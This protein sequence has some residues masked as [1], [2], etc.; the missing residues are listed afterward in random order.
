MNYPLVIVGAGGFGRELLTWIGEQSAGRSSH[1]RGFLDDNPAA[2]E[3]FDIELPILG[4][5]LTYQ[6]S[7]DERLVL[8]IGQPAT[9]LKLAELLRSRGGKFAT[10]IHTS[11]R[12]G[13]R[14]Q[15]GEGVIISPNAG[16]SCDV[17]LGDFVMLNCFATVGHDAHIGRGT[18][19]SSHV[20]CTGNTRIGAGV[21]LGSHA[22]VIPGIAVGDGATVAAGSVAMRNVPA[23]A[24]VLGVPAKKIF[25][26]PVPSGSGDS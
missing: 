12:V 4:D 3:D 11:A 6:P 25:Q 2:L 19:L 14:C 9:K 7:G 1:V 8:A 5:P 21:F 18:T 26:A 13:P 15:L 17:T 22:A 20:D 23:G 24:T 16:V 10:L